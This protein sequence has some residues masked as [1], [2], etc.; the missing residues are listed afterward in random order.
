MIKDMFST[1]HRLAQVLSVPA[2][3]ARDAAES[4]GKG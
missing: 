4:V 3:Y 2:M 1:E